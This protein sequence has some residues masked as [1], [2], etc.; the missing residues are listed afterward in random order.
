MNERMRIARELHDATGHGVNVMSIQAT[1]ALN[2][3]ERDPATARHALEAIRR[4]SRD[5]AEDMR[6]MLSVLRE[7]EATPEDLDRATLARLDPLLQEFRE[8]GIPVELSVEG[9]PIELPSGLDQTAYRV[10]QEALTNVRRHAGGGASA[11]VRVLYAPGNLELEVLDDG[12]PRQGMSLSNGLIGMRERVEA[13]DGRLEAAT[14]H[15]GGFR[16]RAI[17]P[18]RRRSDAAI[19][20]EPTS[21]P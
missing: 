14:R 8:A 2:T 7:R 6:R 12:Q 1:A 5:T 11:R 20:P 21:S 18:L 15:G 17:F 16:I 10:I 4:T 19:R 9:A 13:F 3:L